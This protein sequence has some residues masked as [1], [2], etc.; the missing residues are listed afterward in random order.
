MGYALIMCV[1]ALSRTS[2]ASVTYRSDVS[3][4]TPDLSRAADGDSDGCV[5]V[6]VKFV[7]RLSNTAGM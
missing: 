2:E 4:C 7:A 1:R 3:V 6:C 5:C